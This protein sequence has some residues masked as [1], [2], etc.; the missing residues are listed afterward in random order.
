[1][2]RRSTPQRQT[3]SMPCACLSLLHLR[4]IIEPERALL[5]RRQQRARLLLVFAGHDHVH[6]SESINR[7]AVGLPQRF[8]SQLTDDTSRRQEAL[9]LLCLQLA[10]GGEDADFI[11]HS[12]PRFAS[13]SWHREQARSMSPRRTAP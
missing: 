9:Y 12:K 10:A 5:G 2:Y 13:S 6:H 11:L 8:A 7:Q 1:M 4:I 3:P